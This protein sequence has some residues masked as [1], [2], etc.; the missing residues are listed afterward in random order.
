[1]LVGR[2]GAGPAEAALD[3]VEDQRDPLAVAHLAQPA[4]VAG[5]AGNEP[6]LPL[7]DLDHDRRVL[8][9]AS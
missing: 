8:M 6:A 7:E 5:G 1:M 9:G 2:P 4:Q 3:L